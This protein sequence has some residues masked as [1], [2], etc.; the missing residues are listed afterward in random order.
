[1]LNDAM[2]DLA[3]KMEDEEPNQV[4]NFEQSWVGFGLSSPPHPRTEEPQCSRIVPGSKEL[5]RNVQKL[6]PDQRN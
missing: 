4:L 1:V 6:F 2:V 5:D 3:K